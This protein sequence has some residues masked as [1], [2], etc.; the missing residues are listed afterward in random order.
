MLMYQAYK[1]LAQAAKLLDKPYVEYE[2]TADKL[3][4]DINKYYWD[5][6]KGAFIDSY[7]SGK[8]NVTRHANIF[9]IM[10]DFATE[11]QLES[12]VKN[13]ILND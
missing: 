6:E 2:K 4:A 1:T 7:S 11:S 3:K 9:A 13:V 8:R 10:Y 12:I 5:E